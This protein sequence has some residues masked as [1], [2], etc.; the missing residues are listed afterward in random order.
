MPID[1]G[2]MEILVCTACGGGLDRLA[3]DRGVQCR[4]C[5]R[6]YPFRDGVLIMLEE[7]A[8]IP[9]EEEGTR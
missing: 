3:E 9:G 1:S 5:R 6:I 2:L 7:R 4:E 8:E